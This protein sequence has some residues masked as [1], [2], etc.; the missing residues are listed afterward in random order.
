MK[1][2][3]RRPARRLTRAGF[4][5]VVA[6]AVAVLG[7]PG[8]AS[9]DSRGHSSVDGKEI[10]WED[11]TKYDDARKWAATAWN[12]SQY[13]LTSIKIAPDEWD[14][15]ADLE[16]RDIK[17][18]DVKW[19]GG[20]APRK[21]AD[22]IL[23]NTAFLDSGKKYGAK[24]WRR[25]A[26]AHELGHALGLTHKPNGTLMSKTIGYLPANARPVHTDR[27]AYH[28]LWG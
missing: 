5:G 7:H 3:I 9:A 28:D 25:K 14:T 1:H 2:P 17:R 8:T 13:G 4:L 18:A 21:G 12:N 16:W 22:R 27:A 19:V 20:W 10:R 26:A 11:E 24:G 23:L 15:I 6:V